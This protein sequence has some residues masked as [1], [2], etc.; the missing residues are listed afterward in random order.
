VG[1]KTPLG[2]SGSDGVFLTVLSFSYSFPFLKVEI[3]GVAI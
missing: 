1:I 2:Y 3:L